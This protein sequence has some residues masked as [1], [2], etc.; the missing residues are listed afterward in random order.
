MSVRIPLPFPAAIVF[1]LLLA[2]N[3]GFTQESPAYLDA[4]AQ[5]NGFLQPVGNCLVRFETYSPADPISTEVE[6][7]EFIV[8]L[9]DYGTGIEQP[10]D[11]GPLNPKRLRR[12]SQAYD[13]FLFSYAIVIEEAFPEAV[14][15]AKRVKRKIRKFFRA[16]KRDAKSG[17]AF[18]VYERI[19]VDQFNYVFIW[20]YDIEMLSVFEVNCS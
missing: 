5:L 9:F 18:D 7:R 1:L 2:P 11:L 13:H 15:Y 3:L 12:H 17:S 8:S 16:V 10:T 14:R 20:D 6:A 4:G 19:E